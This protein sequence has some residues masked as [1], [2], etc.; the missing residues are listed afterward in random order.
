MYSLCFDFFPFANQFLYGVTVCV[1]VRIAGANFVGDFC[2]PVDGSMENT[3]ANCVCSLKL[4]EK[5]ETVKIEWKL[6]SPA[7]N[8]LAMLFLVL[9]FPIMSGFVRLLTPRF[10]N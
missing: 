8:S 6:S 5:A 2:R 7:L 1:S 3:S 10:P 4:S 9:Y